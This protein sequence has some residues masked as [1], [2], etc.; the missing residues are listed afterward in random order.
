M[1]RGA[2]C[3]NRRGDDHVAAVLELAG[4]VLHQP[5]RR[6]DVGGEGL[7]QLARRKLLEFVI[8]HLVGRVA[9]QHVEPA[10]CVHG[11]AGQCAAGVLG[12][13]VAGDRP[14]ASA[15]ALHLGDG[16]GGVRLLLGQ[17]RDHHVGPFVRE[18]HGHRTTDARIP[19]GDQCTLAGQ[20][21]AGRP[22]G[23]AVVGGRGQ[24]CVG[25]RPLL[26]LGGNVRQVGHGEPRSS[27]VVVSRRCACFHRTTCG[28][29]R[30]T[31][32]GG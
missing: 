20:P 28:R 23:F 16:F 24:G 15:D 21:A 10:E 6:E 30:D 11:L 2:V 18:Q 12:A 22:T 17:R 14:A 7:L 32:F 31:E 5:E 27:L 3:L 26:A 1:R 9:H 29:P 19:A 25:A 8:G 13:Q 4:E